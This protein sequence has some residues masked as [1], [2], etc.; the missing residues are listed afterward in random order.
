M[1]YIIHKLVAVALIISSVSCKSQNE[2]TPQQKAIINQTKANFVFVKG[3]TFMM[4]KEPY[5]EETPVHQVTLDS[6][7]INKYETTWKE[8]DNYFIATGK[9]ILKPQRRGKIEGYTPN[10]GAK[11]ITWQDARDYCKWL[12]K[13]LNLP[14]DLPTEAQWEYAARSR[15]LDVQHA[16]YNGKIEGSHTVPHNYGTR[17]KVGTYPPNPL[18]LYDMSGGRSEWVRDWFHIYPY[19][20]VTNPVQDTMVKRLDSKVVR[21]EHTLVDSVYRRVRQDPE[22]NGA[23]TGVRCVCN[24]KT[25]IK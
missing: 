21:G 7:S 16:T 6:Y 4:G 14:I 20:P 23:G 2:L 10:H 9:P 8:L 12:G 1:K 11:N 13:K 19:T 22:N 17:D 18:G 15:G 25:P 3:G 5:L 24:Q